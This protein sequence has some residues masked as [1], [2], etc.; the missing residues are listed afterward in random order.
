MSITLY[1]NHYSS[2]CLAVKTILLLTKSE[3]TETAIDIFKGDN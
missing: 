2:R 3:F 1:F